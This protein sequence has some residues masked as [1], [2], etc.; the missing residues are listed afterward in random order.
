MASKT[1]FYAVLILTDTGWTFSR[2]FAGKAAA[3]KWARWCSSRWAA[4]VYRGGPG[5]ECVAEYAAA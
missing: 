1:S 4:K 2:T 5:G 3:Q